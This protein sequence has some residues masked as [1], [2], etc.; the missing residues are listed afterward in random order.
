MSTMTLALTAMN[1]KKKQMRRAMKKQ[2]EPEDRS[3]D[4]S[5]QD[6]RHGRSRLLSPPIWSQK[7]G[8]IEEHSEVKRRPS[9][10]SSQL[11]ARSSNT[12][13]SSQPQKTTSNTASSQSHSKP[14]TGSMTHSTGAAAAEESR[15]SKTKG[16]KRKNHMSTWP[17]EENA[18][19]TTSEATTKS[20][21]GFNKTLLSHFEKWNQDE[22]TENFCDFVL[23]DPPDIDVDD[24]EFEGLLK[25]D[26]HGS[27]SGQQQEAHGTPTS[28]AFRWYQ[29]QQKLAQE[30][31]QQPRIAPLRL[32]KAEDD[33]NETGDNNELTVGPSD[34]DSHSP[35]LGSGEDHTLVLGEDPLAV[36]VQPRRKSH[37]A[38]GSS[39]TASTLATPASLATA[40]AQNHNTVDG[41]TS[42]HNSAV[43]DS[44][45]FLTSSP[46]A[47]M[48]YSEDGAEDWDFSAF[49]IDATDE[50]LH[51]DHDP[52]AQF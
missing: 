38:R 51:H 41:M 37:D 42:N 25:R 28:N 30:L 8:A 6:E 50:Y 48:L 23:S 36:F 49:P 7:R 18:H 44:S 19:E 24:S 47:T 16:R 13:T 40:R 32:G 31:A 17:S 12:A 35:G 26:G 46:G 21:I 10:A 1:E 2:M 20:A 52:L 3:D 43:P 5:D 14:A 22:K 39:L 4:S 34:L 33:A 11:V 29:E 9:V 15:V 45:P 27:S